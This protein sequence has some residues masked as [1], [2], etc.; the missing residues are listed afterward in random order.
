MVGPA[1]HMWTHGRPAGDRQEGPY[2][3]GEVLGLLLL[4][5]WQDLVVP[6]LAVGVQEAFV[7]HLADDGVREPVLRLLPL[8]C[9]VNDEQT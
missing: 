1:W 8:F 2:Q 9:R 4:Q 3:E 6:A 5:M 7:Q